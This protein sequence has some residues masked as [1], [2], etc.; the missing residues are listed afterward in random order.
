MCFLYTTA[1]HQLQLGSHNLT[2]GNI[3]PVKCS[4][5]RRTAS[6]KGSWPNHVVMV[7]SL[8]TACTHPASGAL[9]SH[10]SNRNRGPLRTLG[11][12]LHFQCGCFSIT[13][14]WFQNAGSG[15]ICGGSRSHFYGPLKCLLP[16]F[17]FK[18]LLFQTFS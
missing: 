14:H 2:Q 16:I 4:C 6:S 10:H 11:N 13:G 9:L 15:P 5:C 8:V 17:G 7:N 3:C 18:L 1:S 12:M